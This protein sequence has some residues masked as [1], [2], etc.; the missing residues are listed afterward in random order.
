[1]ILP[2]AAGSHSFLSSATVIDV[3]HVFFGFTT[4]ARPSYA[5]GSSTYSTCVLPQ[6]STSAAAIGRDASA[7]SISSRQNFC[8]AAAGAGD[9]DRHARAGGPP[10]LFGNRLGD[11]VNGAGTIDLDHWSAREIPAGRTS[12]A[13]RRSHRQP[14]HDQRAHH[15]LNAIRTVMRC[16]FADVKS[17]LHPPSTFVGVLVT[18]PTNPFM[19]AST[20]LNVC[21][22]G[23]SARKCVFVSCRSLPS[24]TW[25]ASTCATSRSGPSTSSATRS[26]RCCS[27]KVGQSRSR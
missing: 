19:L 15:A 7:M 13:A 6:A 27:L 24:T 9:S 10:E 4:T 21:W 14:E 3:A 23:G 20:V 1:M 16:G 18:T 2:C 17:A 26:P 11:R 22:Q 25:K 12:A 5:I 8:E